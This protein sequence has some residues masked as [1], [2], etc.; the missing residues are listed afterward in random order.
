MRRPGRI[1]DADVDV[2]QGCFFTK[3]KGKNN[4]NLNNSGYYLINLKRKGEKLFGIYTMQLAIFCEANNI[5]NIP[6][7]YCIH[8]ID[9]N[10]S[11][12][13]MNNLCL[14]TPSWNAMC[15]AQNKDYTAIYEKRKQ[16]GFIQKVRAFSKA[17]TE[18]EYRS[19]SQA[20]R[21][22]G[23]NVCRISRIVNRKPY[24]G[25]LRKNDEIFDF[26]RLTVK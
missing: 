3:N 15:S 6:K 8:H 7:G 4:G 21:D 18:K 23:V 12:N 24:H 11:N 14:C 16:R 2:N 1:F 25:Y 5:K 20:A 9:D 22:F 10:P 17:G 19:M 26:C 13:C